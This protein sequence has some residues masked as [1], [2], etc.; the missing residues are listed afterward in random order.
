MIIKKLR[1]ET[2]YSQITIEHTFVING[3]EIRVYDYQKRDNVFD[4]YDSD[5]S[6][7][8]KDAELLTENELEAVNDQMGE[9]LDTPEGEEYDLSDDYDDTNE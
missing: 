4:D 8:E 5:V 6:I 3:K 1:Q 2:T 9:I 7:D